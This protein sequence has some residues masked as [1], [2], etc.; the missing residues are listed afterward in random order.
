MDHCSYV[1]EYSDT[2]QDDNNMKA[3]VK[4]DLFVKQLTQILEQAD[5]LRVR[6]IVYK[7]GIPS[8][9]AANFLK[10]IL[11]VFMIGTIGTLINQAAP[12]IIEGEEYEIEEGSSHKL[13][14]QIIATLL[15]QFSRESLA[16]DPAEVRARIEEAREAEKQRFIST[17]DKMEKSERAIE[18]QKKVLGIAGLLAIGDTRLAWQ[19]DPDQWVKNQENLR[20]NYAVLTE[21]GRD[22]FAPEMDAPGAGGGAEAGYDVHYFE[23]D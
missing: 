10:E 2:I 5:E 15:Q 7:E 19:Y 16:Y 3:K 8:A 12:V 1:S 13:L 21:I 17:M 11:R 14:R 18:I 20:M 6:R 23:D 22:G 4:L 9:L